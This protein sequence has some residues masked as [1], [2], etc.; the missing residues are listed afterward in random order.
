MAHSQ[1]VVYCYECGSDI[2][3]KAQICPDCGVDQPT[4][5]GGITPQS[6]DAES[7]MSLAEDPEICGNCEEDIQQTDYTC[8]HCGYSPKSIL[9]KRAALIGVLGL[10][11]SV[12]G[13]GLIIGVPLLVWAI[14]IAKR[15]TKRTAATTTTDGDPVKLMG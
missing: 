1:E 9:R 4:D 13:V 15:A 6:N 3:P 2:S 11:A 7:E 5:D 8:P 10:G 14:R 12:T